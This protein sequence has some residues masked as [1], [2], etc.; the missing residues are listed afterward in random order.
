MP[1]WLP[2]LPYPA[3]RELKS[4]FHRHLRKKAGVAILEKHLPIRLLTHSESH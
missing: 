1:S 3:I 4:K 2:L